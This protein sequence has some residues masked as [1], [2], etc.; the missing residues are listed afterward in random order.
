MQEN[1]E[2]V[3]NDKNISNNQEYREGKSKAKT[4]WKH[5]GY[6]VIALCLALLTVVVINLN[7]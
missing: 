6:V 2:G 3:M 5:V 1:K 7:K 4:F